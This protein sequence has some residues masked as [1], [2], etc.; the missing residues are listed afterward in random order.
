MN[1]RTGGAAGEQILV[2]VSQEFSFE[3]GQAAALLSEIVGGCKGLSL[4]SIT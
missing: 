4:R 2:T 3:Y 1:R